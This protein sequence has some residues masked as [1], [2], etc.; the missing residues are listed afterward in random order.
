MKIQKKALWIGIILLVIIIG[1][2]VYFIESSKDDGSLTR[3]QTYKRAIYNSLTCQYSCPIVE[4]NLSGKAEQLPDGKCIN[5]CLSKIKET[6]FNKTSFTEQELLDDSFVYNVTDVI[7]TCKQKFMA[8]DNESILPDSK[9]FYD[10]GLKGLNSL[11]KD[12]SYLG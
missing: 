5:G 7:E 12:Y 6:G 4:V 8:V 2:V 10:C 1:L 9:G 11:K 3:A